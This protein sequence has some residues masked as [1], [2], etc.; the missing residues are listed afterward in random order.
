MESSIK[1]LKF[2]LSIIR[3]YYLISKYGRVA[4]VP[5]SGSGVSGVLRKLKVISD[6]SLKLN[7]AYLVAF[8]LW[9]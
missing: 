8:I 4:L 7:S 9:I 3:F 2:S 1:Y 5:R 6:G